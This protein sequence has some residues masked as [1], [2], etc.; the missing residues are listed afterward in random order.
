MKSYAVDSSAVILL[1]P[2]EDDGKDPKLP[3]RLA[4]ATEWLRSRSQSDR[5][6]LP[7]P[8]LAELLALNPDGRRLALAINGVSA[9]HIAFSRQAAI[10]AAA[11]SREVYQQRKKGIE[12]PSKECLK[13]DI[14]ILATAAAGRADAIATANARDF[15]NYGSIYERLRASG[16]ILVPGL[17]RITIEAI[18]EI[19]PGKQA[20]LAYRK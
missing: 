20:P 6:L 18:D 1:T 12:F 3:A 7:A 11:I 9:I 15:R 4:N 17:P 2:G 10:V 16:Q 14:M 5:L 8:V 13:F 19:A